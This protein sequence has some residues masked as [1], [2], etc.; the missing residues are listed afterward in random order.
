MLVKLGVDNTV[1]CWVADYRVS[2]GASSNNNGN[3]QSVAVLGKTPFLSSSGTLSASA[4]RLL[5][6]QNDASF[7]G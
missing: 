6:H 5:N 3:S 7:I 2:R 1:V 4:V